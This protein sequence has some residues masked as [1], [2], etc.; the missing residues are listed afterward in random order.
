[1][2]SSGNSGGNQKSR[3]AL[4]ILLDQYPVKGGFLSLISM[5]LVFHPAANAP[6]GT[7]A[8]E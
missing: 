2:H 5:P 6:A 8:N 1:M 7:S 4:S 3:V